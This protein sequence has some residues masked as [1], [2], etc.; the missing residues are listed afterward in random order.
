MKFIQKISV[1]ICKLIKGYNEEKFK[2][3][4]TNTVISVSRRLE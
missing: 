2:S 4:I 1:I 3:D